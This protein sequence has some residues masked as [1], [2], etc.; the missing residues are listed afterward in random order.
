MNLARKMLLWGEPQL[1]TY[2]GVSF[3]LANLP[4]TASWKLAP[5]VDSHLPIALRPAAK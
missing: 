5:L 1:V 4:G 3:Q 2:R